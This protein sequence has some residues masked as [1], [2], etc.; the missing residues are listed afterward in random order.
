MRSSEDEEWAQ[1]TIQM[2]MTR[3]CIIT[4]LLSGLVRKTRATARCL[5]RLPAPPLVLSSRM[6][7]QEIEPI[8]GHLKSDHR[9]DRC[10]LKGEQVD[11]LHAVPCATGYNS[12]LL[13]DELSGVR[14]TC[15]CGLRRSCEKVPL[16]G[17]C[18]GIVGSAAMGAAPYD[19]LYLSQRNMHAQTHCRTTCWLESRR[20]GLQQMAR[21]YPGEVESR[22]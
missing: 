6:P 21:A 11:R 3:I 19:Q 9:M 20:C 17:P 16:D 1:H 5:G 2:R 12:K 8:I 4:L 15:G 18:G 22:I 14:W 7:W 10:H 13:F